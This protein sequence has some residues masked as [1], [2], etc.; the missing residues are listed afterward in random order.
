MDS[1]HEMKQVEE[2]VVGAFDNAHAF[3]DG[4]F[5]ALAVRALKSNSLKSSRGVVDSCL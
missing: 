1:R 4:L 5:T 3:V 2:I